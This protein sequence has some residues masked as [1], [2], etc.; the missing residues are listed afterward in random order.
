MM[1]ALPL[2]VRLSLKAEPV[3]FSKL[4]IVST[5]APPVAWPVLMARLIVMTLRR[6]H[7]DPHPA[8]VAGIVTT[9]AT[10]A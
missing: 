6:R 4:E 3:R 10:I 7:D 2:P 1:L 5:P 9:P 8:R